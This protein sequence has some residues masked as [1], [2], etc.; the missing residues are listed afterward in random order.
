METGN[1]EREH[2]LCSDMKSEGVEVA[3]EER[4]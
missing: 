3:L 4:E 1:G 2:G